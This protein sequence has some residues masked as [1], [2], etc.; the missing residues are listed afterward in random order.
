MPP[1]WAFSSHLGNLKTNFSCPTTSLCYLHSLLA[2]PRPWRTP[3]P[4]S[5]SL[6]RV[7]TSRQSHPDVELFLPTSECFCY[8][9][10][11]PLS[12]S[13][14]Q[15]QLQPP[16]KA[17]LDLTWSSSTPS[18]KLFLFRHLNKMLTLLFFH[19]SMTHISLV[20]HY[21]FPALVFHHVL[22]Q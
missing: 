17:L 2:S 21:V 5:V 8:T 13:C 7:G 15:N 6:L 10:Q 3:S 22:V 18:R 16:A 14:S 11:C 19:N 9:Q 12:L 20:S 4:L 1:S